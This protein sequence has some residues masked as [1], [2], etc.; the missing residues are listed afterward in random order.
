M[1]A[2]EAVKSGRCDAM[3]TAPISKEAWHAAGITRYP[4]HTEL[5]GEAFESPAS[6]MLFVG[7][8][9]RVMLATI[10]VALREV[11]RAIERLGVAGVLAKIELCERAARELGVARPRVAVA[12][13][14][15]H[16]GEHGL[17]GRE[18]QDVL[19][20]A[21]LRARALGIE[22]S[23]P[24]PG[25]AVFMQAAD[26]KHDVVL[27]MYHDQGLIP[28]KLVDRRR[29]VNTTVGLAWQGRAVVRTSPAHGTAYDI[30]GKGVADATSM[31]EALLLA[32]RMARAS[33][34]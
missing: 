14:N 1:G 22:A 3:V 20:P 2:I 5:L 6:A 13:L 8:T 25:D 26:G 10:H 29:T 30:A 21:V 9:L 31:K 15:P 12:G 34:D 4:G 7:P 11:P 27:A 33:R 18:D 28:V 17:F 16:A 32:A 19:A 24:H 23:G